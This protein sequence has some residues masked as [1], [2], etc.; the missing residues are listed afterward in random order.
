MRGQDGAAM[1]TALTFCLA[2][3]LFLIGMPCLAAEFTVDRPDDAVDAVPGDGVCSTAPDPGCSLRAAIQETNALLGPDTIV[4]P[5]GT[6]VLSIAGDDE[7]A[8]A[9]GDLDITDAVSIVGAGTEETI[10]DA[11][12]LDRVIDMLPADAPRDVALTDLTLRNGYLDE[13]FGGGVHP[14]GAGLRVG[15][16]VQLGLARVTLRD[17]RSE[18]QREAAGISNRGCII[19]ERVRILDNLDLSEGFNVRAGGVFTDGADS[20]LTLVDS[21]LRGNRGDTGGIHAESDASVILR[22]TLITDN[23]GRTGAMLLNFTNTALLENVTISGNRGALSAVLND[24]GSTLT[25]INS[26]VT[27]NVGLD[28]DDEP[29]VGGIHDV[30]GGF[31]LTFLS[32]TILSGNGPGFL[33]DDCRSAQSLDGGNIVGDSKRCIFQSLPSDQLDVD[34]GLEPLADNGGFTETHLPGPNAVDHGVE[35]PCPATDQRGV[36][37]PF[38]GDDDGAAHCDVGAVEQLGETGSPPSIS[39]ADRREKELNSGLH[40]MRFTLTL[41]STS[42]ETVTV[43]YATEDDTAIAGVDYFAASGTV[44]FDP[45]ETSAGIFVAI[46]PN[47][48]VQDNRRFFVNLSN[49]GGATIEGGTAVGT[50]FDDDTLAPNLSVGNAGTE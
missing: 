11:A 37:R 19:G 14:G 7:D 22:R 9:T 30:H 24:G 38:D 39:I 31:G 4:V 2:G 26:T 47:T 36:E 16:Q 49:P 3:W 34:P 15:L 48:V 23:V 18:R 42:D 20:C 40:L 32:N 35:G 21:E 13:M 33:A 27:A 17:N 6:F 45:G 5:A 10:L 28:P 44:T 46:I 8:A 43:D 1:T 50:I 25:L 12:A 41:S 29:I